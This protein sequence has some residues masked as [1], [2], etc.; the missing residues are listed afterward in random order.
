MLLE[1]VRVLYSDI[2]YDQSLKHIVQLSIEKCN[3][4]IKL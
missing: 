4:T 3:I 2:F 1:L